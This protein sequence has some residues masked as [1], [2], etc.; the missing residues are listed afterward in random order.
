MCVQSMRTLYVI[1]NIRG[2]NSENNKN[3]Q[4]VP[5]RAQREALKP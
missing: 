3:I 2:I 1:W 4:L 5:K